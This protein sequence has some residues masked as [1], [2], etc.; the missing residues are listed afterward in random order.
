MIVRIN[1]RPRFGP[2]VG[3]AFKASKA[4]ELVAT[5]LSESSPVKM[6]Q[7]FEALAYTNSRC[8]NPCVHVVL[9]PA[10][11]ERLTKRQWQQLCERTAGELGAKQW[12]G[13][14]HND[15]DIQH[16]SL[17]LSRIRPNGKTWSTS[18]DRHR[19]RRICMEFEAEHGLKATVERS[20]G[21]RIDKDEIEKAQRLN[22]QGR[23]WTAVP[24]RLAIPTTTKSL[25]W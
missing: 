2:V 6:T 9:S 11:G 25:P 12:V 8:K 17:V 14:L 20:Q 10:A 3:Y 5:S 7:E 19:L 13:C 23:E 24:P 21:I 22:R 15:T 18:N 1:H 4:P 16:C